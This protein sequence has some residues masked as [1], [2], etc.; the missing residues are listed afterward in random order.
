MESSSRKGFK[1][2]RVSRLGTYVVGVIVG[3]TLTTAVGAIAGPRDLP[4]AHPAIVL[5]KNLAED[6]AG[7]VRLVDY[8]PDG[9]P[10]VYR[11]MHTG[12]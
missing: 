2:M 4:N 5:C 7:H 9:H 8:G 10:L 12:Y 6:T 3:A 1:T 11:C